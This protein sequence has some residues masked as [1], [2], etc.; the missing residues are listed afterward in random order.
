VTVAAPHRSDAQTSSV[1][2]LVRAHLPL[3]GHL[4]REVLHRVP[5]HVSRDDLSSAGM[6]SLVLSAQNFDPELGVPFGRFAAIRIRGALIDELRTMDW[7]SRAVRSKARDLESTRNQLTAVL[8]RTPRAVEV[9]QAMGVTV[10]DLESIDRDVHRA[11]LLSLQAMTTD[12]HENVLPS[13]GDGPE[14]LL[15]K[16]EQLGYLRDAIDEL[17]E[18]L[19]TVIEQYFFGQRRMA[20]IAAELGV[21]ESRISQLRSEALTLLRAGMTSLDGDA[22]ISPAASA[23]QTRRSADAR[24][25][26]CAAVASRSNVGSRLAATTP[27][28][29]MRPRTHF[30]RAATAPVGAP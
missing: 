3:V 8:G 1:D 25:A 6:L 18:R 30:S 26:Y 4:V 21:T 17:P 16:R 9:A 29:E 7:A 28:A 13:V 24:S 15:L 12:D 10:A 22:S 23:P 19:R 20:D 14:E 11:S 5:A 2:E 27:L